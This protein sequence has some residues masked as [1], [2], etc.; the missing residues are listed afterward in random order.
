MYARANQTISFRVSLRRILQ[1]LDLGICNNGSFATSS[2]DGGISFGCPVSSTQ[3]YTALNSPASFSFSNVTLPASALSNVD[4]TSPLSTASGSFSYLTNYQSNPSSVHILTASVSSA[5]SL[6][7]NNTNFRTSPFQISTSQVSSSMPV[8][9]SRTSYL[10]GASLSSLLSSSNPLGAFANVSSVNP[11]NFGNPSANS[12]FLASSFQISYRVGSVSVGSSFSLKIGDINIMNVLIVSPSLDATTSLTCVASGSDKSFIGVR[13]LPNQNKLQC[14][15]LPQLNNA[16]VAVYPSVITPTLFVL[17]WDT[18]ALD[19]S[20]AS[21][22]QR[23]ILSAQ[24]GSSNL[25][26]DASSMSVDANGNIVASSSTA[27]SWLSPSGSSSPSFSSAPAGGTSVNAFSAL[28]LPVSAVRARGLLG[29]FTQS[30]LASFIGVL[31]SS[32]DLPAAA[33]L[34]YASVLSPNIP[35]NSFSFSFTTGSRAGLYAL[36]DGFSANC[37]LFPVFDVPEAV[38]VT[39]C[40]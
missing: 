20:I 24:Y 33:F 14:S 1:A 27:T 18:T 5:L 15:I 19:P 30:Q 22:V 10:T 35:S 16:S 26:S 3:V 34:G 39:F 40:N 6:A 9:L 23:F 11:F 36:W 25:L 2:T 7:A 13:S 32:S 38:D 31:G 17:S 21:T 28:S 37:A 12:S 4:P 29:T 8:S